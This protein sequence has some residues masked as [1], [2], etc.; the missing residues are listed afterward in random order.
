MGV[1]IVMPSIERETIWSAPAWTPDFS[2]TV[3]QWDADPA[4]VAGVLAADLV[5]NARQGDVAFDGRVL[6]QVGEG[7]RDLAI[8]HAVDPEAPL[9]GR[10]DRDLQR[11]INAIEIV[12]RCEERTRLRRSRSR[13]RLG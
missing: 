12:V 13:R 9:I 10:D 1:P 8:D 5:G 3:R 7:E 2:R 4:G 6:E 11:G